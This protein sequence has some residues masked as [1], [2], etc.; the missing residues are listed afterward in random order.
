M[1]T[2]WL[3]LIVTALTDFAL[4]FATGLSTAMA[5]SHVVGLPDI[6]T[7]IVAALGG[8][9]VALRTIQQALKAT[10]ANT[11]DLKGQEPPIVI[12]PTAPAIIQLKP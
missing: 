12:P 2:A 9:V 8:F 7:V 3:V 1:K 11:A 10:A 6:T 5:T 4:T